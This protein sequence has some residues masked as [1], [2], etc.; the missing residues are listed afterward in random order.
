MFLRTDEFQDSPGARRSLLVEIR[1]QPPAVRYTLIAIAVLALLGLTYWLVGGG[2]Q[3]ARQCPRPRSRL[4]IRFSATSLNMT[5]SPGGSNLAA[6]SR[7]APV[8]R[9]S[10]R[11]STSV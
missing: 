4:L 6:Q 2:K 5:N 1:R 10:S 9:G 7:S 8:F 3:P 11:A